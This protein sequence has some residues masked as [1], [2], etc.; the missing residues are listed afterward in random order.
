MADAPETTSAKPPR[1]APR[2]K[3]ASKG[4]GGAPLPKAGKRPAV[5]AITGADGFLGSNALNWLRSSEQCEKVVV[6]DIRKPALAIRKT[7]FYKTDLTEPNCDARIADIFE[8]EGVTRVIHC[9]FTNWPKVNNT[10]LH[11]LEVI[12]T[13]NI[14]NAC[15][16]CRVEQIVVPSTA[17]V[18]DA[19]SSH[20]NFLTED[21]PL[22]EIVDFPYL[23]NRVEVAELL[24]RHARRHQDTRVTVLRFAT[25]LGPRIRTYETRLLS[26]SAVPTIMGYDPLIQFLHED[27]A[28]EAFRLA[29]EKTE[30]SGI[31]N[32]AGRGVLPLS[33]ILKI[34][35]KFDMA[36]PAFAARG[37]VT[38][39][40][41]GGVT[42]I[43]P[44]YLR[45]L[46]FLNV[47]DTAKAR[48]QLGFV[49]RF[50]TKEAWLAFTGEERLRRY[51]S[52]AAA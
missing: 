22:R 50:S 17:K 16:R 13:L 27:D 37:I 11:E 4:S 44:A 31:F 5:V 25:I 23:Q 36:L 1:K 9:A 8:K 46:Q 18:Y 47:A 43:P 51:V 39:L 49:P 10:D 21:M 42:S 6:I 28:I 45:F 12:G 35:G 40:W 52:E 48:E 3:R 30:V 15:A 26:R 7:V 2:P 38:S 32:I 33:T 20:P 24:A 41:L 14:L 29:M 19:A 34:G